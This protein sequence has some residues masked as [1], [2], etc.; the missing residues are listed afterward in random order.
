MGPGSLMFCSLCSSPMGTFPPPPGSGVCRDR[1]RQNA[2]YDSS[3]T[4]DEDYLLSLL[5]SRSSNFDVMPKRSRGMLD[6]GMTRG[7]SGAKAAKARLGLKLANDPFG[8]GR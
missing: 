6:F 4:P 2:V 7:A 5:R 1:D 3:L 8:P